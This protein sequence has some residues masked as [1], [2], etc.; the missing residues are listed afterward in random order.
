MVPV[1]QQL[2]PNEMNPETT[3]E[4]QTVMTI[5]GPES[6]SGNHL[7]PGLSLALPLAM[8]AVQVLGPVLVNTMWDVGC[9]FKNCFSHNNDETAVVKIEP[10]AEDL[11]VEDE[12]AALDEIAENET[13]N[14]GETAFDQFED[15]EKKM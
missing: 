10:G 2:T 1:P 5:Q 13:A 8:A 4:T 9:Y 15:I 6:S 11:D 14:Q 3:A 7:S 12:T